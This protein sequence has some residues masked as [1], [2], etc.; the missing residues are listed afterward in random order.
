MSVFFCQNLFLQESVNFTGMT[1]PL[2]SFFLDR[3][4]VVVR[5]N[6]I[7][8]NNVAEILYGHQNLRNVNV[9]VDFSLLRNNACKLL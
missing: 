3:R 7:D 8:V 6:V 1:K 9:F 4:K 2:F 5:C